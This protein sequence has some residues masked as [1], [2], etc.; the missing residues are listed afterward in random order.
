MLL[1]HFL[2]GCSKHSV[3]VPG[4]H[5][6]RQD[7]SSVAFYFVIS[8]LFRLVCC[9]CTGHCTS[10]QCFSC[11]VTWC[12]PLHMRRYRAVFFLCRF[13]SQ[14]LKKC[15][16]CNC[17]PRDGNFHTD[18]KVLNLDS[19]KRLSEIK[20]GHCKFMSPESTFSGY[21]LNQKGSISSIYR[22]CI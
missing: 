16:K 10:Y 11:Q 8:N 9:L 17:F 12:F 15:R 2:A 3:P 4:M 7:T 6:G 22:L 20:G 1:S 13:I 19:V 18:N 14:S 5:P 21:L